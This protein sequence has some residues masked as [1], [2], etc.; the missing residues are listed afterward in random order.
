MKK[1]RVAFLGLFTAF[2][3]ILSFVESQIP[4]FVAIPGIKLG[5]PNIAIIIILY[6]FGWKEASIISLLRVVLTSLLFG[7]VLSMLYSIAG[8]V[9]SLVAMILLKK[10]LSTVTIS[11]IGGVCHNIGQI[12]VAILVT[13]TQQLLYYLPVLIISGVIAGIVVGIIA[14]LSVKKIEKIDL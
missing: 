10:V 5:L 9:L 1:S 13:E 4:T 2:A 8:A 7:T 3:M 12:L 6:R 11:V 14:A